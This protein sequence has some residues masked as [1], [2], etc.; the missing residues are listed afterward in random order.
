MIS[1]I[2]ISPT[3]I[4]IIF[5]IVGIVN[6][7]IVSVVVSEIFIVVVIVVHW[8][9]LLFW[10]RLVGVIVVWVGILLVIVL[11]GL[12]VV[13]VVVPGIVGFGLSDPELFIILFSTW[14]KLSTLNFFLFLTLLIPTIPVNQNI[15]QSFIFFIQSRPFYLPP[16]FLLHQLK[17]KIRTSFKGTWLGNRDRLI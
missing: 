3:F 14:L 7:I 1:I 2:I 13:V 10:L 12:V 15:R 17:Q 16:I 9:F 11:G 8:V 4:S 5:I 6:L